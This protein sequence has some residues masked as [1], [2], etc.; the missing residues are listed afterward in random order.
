MPALS[1][2]R[3]NSHGAFLGEAMTQIIALPDNMIRNGQIAGIGRGEIQGQVK[4]VSK[5]LQK[6]YNFSCNTAITDCF[7][8]IVSLIF[9]ASFS[10]PNLV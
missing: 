8:F 5:T 9:R 3:G 10:R 1:V 4:F 2:L 6:M 7:S